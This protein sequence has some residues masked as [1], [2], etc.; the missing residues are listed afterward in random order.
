MYVYKKAHTGGGYSN[1]VLAETAFTV[2]LYNN[3]TSALPSKGWIV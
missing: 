1:Q 2:L 3:I